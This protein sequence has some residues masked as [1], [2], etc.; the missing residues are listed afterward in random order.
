MG[1]WEGFSRR[2]TGWNGICEHTKQKVY[3]D[4]GHWTFGPRNSPQILQHHQ[5]CIRWAHNIQSEYRAT[6]VLV[7][8]AQFVVPRSDQFV[9]L[10]LSLLHSISTVLQAQIFEDVSAP[11][12]RKSCH[13]EFNH[14]PLQP[15]ESGEGAEAIPD[16]VLYRESENDDE[17]RKLLIAGSVPTVE[18]I[19]RFEAVMC[20]IILAPSF[21]NIWR[22]GSLKSRLFRSYCLFS[23]EVTIFSAFCRYLTLLKEHARYPS[24]CNIVAIIYTNRITSMGLMPLTVYNWRAIWVVSVIIAQ[25]MWDDKPLKTSS[26]VHILPSFTKHLLRNLELKALNL[27]QFSSGT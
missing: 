5:L 6:F 13:P 9:T 16:D 19:Y 18:V 21:C 1:M 3:S 11:Q 24:E 23:L 22:N 12:D 25:K 15:S 27:I 10:F 4:N 2:A 8:N 20:S 7:W 26:F 17:L 14:P